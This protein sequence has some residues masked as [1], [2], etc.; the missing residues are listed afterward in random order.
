[1]LLRCA[2]P[3]LSVVGSDFHT[4][5]VLDGQDVRAA[6]AEASRASNTARALAGQPHL[7][8]TDGC[9]QRQF[10]DRRHPRRP[11]GRARLLR[12]RTRGAP[13]DPATSHP[14]LAGNDY[15]PEDGRNIRSAAPISSPFLRIQMLSAG[16]LHKPGAAIGQPELKK[17][18]EIQTGTQASYR[19]DQ[20]LT[21]R[22][23]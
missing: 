4:T 23:W 20:P 17:A 3:W 18:V 2:Y 21:S 5:I 15:Q 16:I 1:M 8:C 6:A 22:S 19:I 13:H 11:R 7:P 12:M 14:A 10:C 9:R